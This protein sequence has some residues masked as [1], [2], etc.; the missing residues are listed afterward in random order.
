VTQGLPQRT[1]EVVAV[2]GDGVNDASA[3][4]TAGIGV[5]MG[6]AGTDVSK[7]T[8][9]MALADD[10]SGM[11]EG[12]GGT[13]VAGTSL[14]RRTILRGASERARLTPRLRERRATR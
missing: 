11:T 9:D 14:L 5:A 4:K 1:G 8:A 13:Q 6:V 12:K 2:T 3:L 10:N 7:E